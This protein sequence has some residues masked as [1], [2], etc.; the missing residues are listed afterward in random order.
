M[1]VLVRVKSSRWKYSHLVIILK[2]IALTLGFVFRAFSWFCAANAFTTLRSSDATPPRNSLRIP[3]S[4]KI[5]FS[6]CGLRSICRRIRARAWASGIHKPPATIQ[7]AQSANKYNFREISDEKTRLVCE[8]IRHLHQSGGKVGLEDSNKI[9]CHRSYDTVPI[10]HFHVACENTCFASMSKCNRSTKFLLY[11]NDSH[12]P[13][14][15]RSAT[16]RFKLSRKWRITYRQGSH[17]HTWSARNMQHKDLS[18][19][20]VTKQLRSLSIFVVNIPQVQ[21]HLRNI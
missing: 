5:C 2:R 20:C 7:K 21:S 10:W 18:F 15:T 16:G 9:V 12:I 14:F 8:E 17:H 13:R 19:Q 1:R 4:S 11:H 6:R 3:G